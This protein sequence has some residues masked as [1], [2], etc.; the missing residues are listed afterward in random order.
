MIDFGFTLSKS[1]AV[2]LTN[3]D[4][5]KFNALLEVEPDAARCM[6]CGSCAG[7]CSAGVFA[8]MSLRRVIAALQR[9]ADKEAL[10]ML[11]HCMLCGK[12]TLVCPRGLNTRH[13]I[14]SIMKIYN[15]AD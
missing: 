10:S 9:G 7:S 13:I 8:P 3:I 2:N 1:S 6:T 11:S 5:S 14:L 12:C 15:T 4:D